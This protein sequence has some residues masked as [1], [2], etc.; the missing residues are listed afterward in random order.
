MVNPEMWGSIETVRESAEDWLAVGLGFVFCEDDSFVGVDLDSA[1]N[2]S[3]GFPMEWPDE[4]IETLDSYTEVSP[5]GMS[6]QVLFE[7]KLLPGRNRRVYAELYEN[8]RFLHT[9]R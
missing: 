8:D 1:R 6:F 5:S 9:D 3:I 4:I 2:P 7:G